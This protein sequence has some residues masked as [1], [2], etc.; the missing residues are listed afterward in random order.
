MA[1][2]R[3]STS[4]IRRPMMRRETAVTAQAGRHDRQVCTEL[5]QYR[6]QFNC[7]DWPWSRFPKQVAGSE[8]R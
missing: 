6:G 1:A 7:E 4:G 5:R 2:I 8:G 3:Q